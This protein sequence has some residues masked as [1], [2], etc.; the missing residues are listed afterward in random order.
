M[1]SVLLQIY[2]S[3]SLIKPLL[4][5]CTFIGTK[6]K[7]AEELIRRNS[8]DPKNFFIVSL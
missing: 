1:Y 6:Q 2:V 4:I 3:A 8:L 7:F 5:F